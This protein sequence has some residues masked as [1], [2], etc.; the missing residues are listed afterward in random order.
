[1]NWDTPWHS[2]TV[3]EIA[4]FLQT[5]TASGL[6]R[7]EAKKRL[8][9]QG[10]NISPEEWH[11]PRKKFIKEA[12]HSILPI[13]I[14]ILFYIDKKPILSIIFLIAGVIYPIFRFYFTEITYLFLSIKG[15]FLP[16]ANVLRDGEF[17]SVPVTAIVVGDVLE[18]LSGDRVPA[19]VR[20]FCS[21]LLTVDESNLFEGGAEVSKSPEP[22]AEDT[23]PDQQR[24]MLFAG[25]VVK[26]GRALGIVVATG[27]NTMLG[28]LP[29]YRYEKPKA[30]STIFP[31]SPKVYYS[32]MFVT[33]ATFFIGWVKGVDIE[34]IVGNLACLL[35]ATFG[36][37]F[38]VPAFFAILSSFVRAGKKGFYMR[39]PELLYKMNDIDC[40]CIGSDNFLLKE[41]NS[42]VSAVANG[43]KIVVDPQK[44]ELEELFAVDEEVFDNY[45]RDSLG[46]L[47]K[48]ASLSNL[49]YSK[50]GIIWGS[51]REIGIFELVRRTGMRKELIGELEP[52][53][54]ERADE[55]KGIQ[56]EFRAG[57][58]TISVLKGDAQKLLNLCEYA[59]LNQDVYKLDIV[60][61]D[62]LHEKIAS[63][64][65]EGVEKFGFAYR[66]THPQD[67]EEKGF[68]FVGI[69]GIKYA[70][71]PQT[72]SSIE[73]SIKGGKKLVIFQEAGFIPKLPGTMAI[74]E[75]EKLDTV[76]GRI[77]DT[78]ILFLPELGER[79][80]LRVVAML[81]ESGYRLAY[82]GTGISDFEPMRIS[83]VS[84]ADYGRGLCIAGEIADVKVETKP[85][86]LPTLKDAE[87]SLYRVEKLLLYLF[88]VS[89]GL[90]GSMLGLSLFSIPYPIL[91]PYHMVWLGL[92]VILPLTTLL[93]LES[94][95]GEK[96]LWEF[97][98]FTDGLL[99]GALLVLEMFF[100]FLWNLKGTGY[101][102]QSR[103]LV[104]V[105][106]IFAS[107]FSIFP[108]YGSSVKQAARSV[109]KNNRF[110]WISLGI[111]ALNIAVVL[112]PFNLTHYG[113]YRI[114]P[115]KVVMCLLLGIVTACFVL[116]IRSI[117]TRE[118]KGVTDAGKEV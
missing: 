3:E 8:V 86:P 25:T 115:S 77:E 99:L 63:V 34:N 11:L 55:I 98:P 67:T 100:L 17:V 49:I 105:L 45:T 6:S 73:Q 116:L 74:V 87:F 66:I 43:K 90:T 89:L 37:I 80:K 35:A 82:V 39:Y 112:S 88:F 2:F 61:R 7:E 9:H 4:R 68:I 78:D 19:N 27:E 70:L 53:L 51:K 75:K 94:T 46:L 79:G 83:D 21:F 16:R 12:L 47:L 42:V 36:I 106:A 31:I 69:L 14:S 30:F 64:S 118:K 10:E 24:N 85:C 113:I 108:L 5:D 50:D 114:E 103:T 62:K 58:D 15:R 38:P 117:R 81:K 20:I 93:S 44:V 72:Y 110:L 1:M 57:Q 13:F 54:L 28:N 22:L 48:M 33:F 52:F 101:L 104:F 92:F 41:H 91:S 56:M 29:Q 71:N 76:A 111:I 26:S 96:P 65:S 18:L 102:N 59:Y 97:H 84:I 109:W 23:P 95:Y 60:L 107:G 32:V 40:L